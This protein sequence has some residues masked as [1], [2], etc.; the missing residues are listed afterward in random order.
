MDFAGKT[1]WLLLCA[2]YPSG[3]AS[4]LELDE[5][6]FFSHKPSIVLAPDLCKV[7]CLAIREARQ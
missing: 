3:L 6:R 4:A 1:G 2:K 7:L 5:R